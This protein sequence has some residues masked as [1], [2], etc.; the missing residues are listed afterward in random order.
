MDISH[1]FSSHG[2]SQKSWPS[3]KVAITGHQRFPDDL[4]AAFVVESI[5]TLLNKL[6]TRHGPALVAISGLAEGADTMFAEQA[7]RLG[8]PVEAILAH[9]NLA[10]SLSSAAAQQRFLSVLSNCRQVT[11]LPYAA[12][13]TAAYTMLGRVLVERC[14]LLVAV[15]DG[16][17][18]VDEGGTGAVVAHARRQGRSIAHISTRT[19][20][21]SCDVL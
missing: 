15:W 17:P 21:I 10:Q 9:A 19:R 7:L 8:I 6:Q 20:T 12:P 11:M 2:A 13:S 3:H 16:L 14:D 5:H 4:V 18:P 1:S